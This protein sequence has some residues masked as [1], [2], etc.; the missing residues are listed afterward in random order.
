MIRIKQLKQGEGVFMRGSQLLHSV[1]PLLGG[2]TWKTMIIS[3][4]QVDR[5]QMHDSTC[6]N[7]FKKDPHCF[8][9]FALHKAWVG[10]E[11]LTSFCHQ[12]TVPQS[13]TEIIEALERVEQELPSTIGILK[14]SLT[15]ERKY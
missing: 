2:K 5:T 13:E 8:F 11:L 14:G 9:E 7:T 12:P 4:H 6:F 10:Q 1:S 15:E 3:Y